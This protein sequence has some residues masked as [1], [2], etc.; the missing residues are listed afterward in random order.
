M[1]AGQNFG[2]LV[3]VQTYAAD[4]E[5]LVNLADHGT[6]KSGAFTGHPKTLTWASLFLLPCTLRRQTE[7]RTRRV[8]TEHRGQNGRSNA[9]ATTRA[10]ASGNLWVVKDQSL[11]RCVFFPPSILSLREEMPSAQTDTPISSCGFRLQL[12]HR[13]RI[14]ENIPLDQQAAKHVTAICLFFCPFAVWKKR[15]HM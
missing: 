3:A 13:R 9:T 12:K 4:Q 14:A 5:L 15:I 11:E 10:E 1:Q 7:G 8:R 6:G 2:V